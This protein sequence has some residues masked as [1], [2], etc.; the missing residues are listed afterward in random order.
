M[1][2]SLILSCFLGL[3]GSVAFGAEQALDPLDNWHQWRGPLATGVA[4]KG[5]PPIQWNEKTNIKWKVAIP[6]LGNASP[7]VWGDQVFVLTAI[8]SGR[9]ADPKDIPKPDPAFKVRTQPPQTYHQF[10]VLSIDRQTGKIRWQQVATEQ[11]PHEGRQPTHTYAGASPMTDGHYLYVSFGSRGIFCFDLKG[12]L[13]WKTDLGLMHTRLGWGEGISPVVHGDTLLMNWDQEAGSFI[14]ALDAKT[15][16]I[17]WKKDRDEVTSW[18]TPLIVPLNGRVQAI[19]SATKKVRSYDLATGDVI[20]ECGGQTTNVI[21]SPVANDKFVICM[22]GY[23]GAMACAI[24]LNASTDLTGTNQLIWK[25]DK[26]TPYVPSPLLIRDRLYF[27]QGNNAL[28]TCL[29]T[30]T[31]K[32]VMDRERLPGLSGIYASPVAAAGRI[33]LT[34]RDG[35]VLVIKQA[36]KLEILATNRLPDPIDASPAIVGKQIFLRGKEHLYCLEEK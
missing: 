32:P 33:Y 28:L 3:V 4:P 29:D 7:I 2:K 35:T 19:V 34:G 21:P 5:N 31:G 18:A 11:V 27:T 25:Y 24:P 26:G 14:A 12:N 9:M 13:Q 1:R 17:K 6:G 20:W 16:K 36:D 30:S 22:S 15:G 8:D 23:Q 10:V